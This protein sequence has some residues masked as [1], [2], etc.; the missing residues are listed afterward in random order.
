MASRFF[1]ETGAGGFSSR[2]GTVEFYQRVNALLS[3]DYEILD[4][5]AGRGGWYFDDANTYRR[6]L[7]LIRGKVARVVGCD[8]D[9]AIRANLSIDEAY[10]IKP[11]ERLPFDDASFDLIVADYVL[12]HIQSP[13]EFASEILRLLKAGGWFCARTP[14]KYGYTAIAARTIPNKLH[15]CVLKAVQPERKEIDV[16]PTTFRLNCF[17]ALNKS[18]PPHEFE[19][20]SY[21]YEVEPAYHFNNRIVFLFCLFLNW[22]V[23]PTMKSTLMIFLRKR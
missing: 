17:S 6:E 15:T 2:D 9:E 5:G 11:G 8:V 22:L 14:N 3:D 19:N 7:R 23:P 4:L 16:F 18:F 12:E 13:S 10:L 20:F 1:I 21:R